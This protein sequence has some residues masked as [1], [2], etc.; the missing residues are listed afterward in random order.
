MCSE[1]KDFLQE[2]GVSL[3]F[4]NESTL[5]ENLTLGRVI[6][7][8]KGFYRVVTKDKISLCELSG[9]L[10]HEISEAAQYPTV[11]DFVMVEFP[12]EEGN[13]SIKNILSRKSM[14]IRK[15]VGVKG[16][17]QVVSAN[18]DIIFICMSL[19]ENYN[20]NRLE[21]YLSVA[22]DSGAK[23]VIVLTKSDLCE[24]INKVIY[25]VEKVSAYS[26][27]I[28]VSIYDEDI[29][30]KFK[31]YFNEETTASFIGSSGVGKSTLINKL[32]K[33]DVI[34]TGGLSR[35]DKGKHT[36]TVKQMHPCPFGGVLIDTPGMREIGL[37]NAD[38][39]KA[40]DD[41]DKLSM[42]C[43]FN[44]CTH[45]NEPGCAV[46]KAVEEGSVDMRRLENYYKLINESSYEGLNSKEIEK[47]KAN[48][49]FAEVGGMK[50]ARKYM[51]KNNK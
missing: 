9:K 44:D 50:N 17:G 42:E 28:T 49:M 34:L 21:R 6:A 31:G 20:L 45:T 35:D 14:F 37:E 3:R 12:L 7:E 38:V 16:Q 48:R 10:R 39:S 29:I 23:P 24:D 15:S 4:I 40:F 1:K 5:Y 19:N 47:K 46:L 26:D 13:G 41:I 51:K 30:S 36:T 25:E 27:V 22:F 8:Y 32:L 43:K 11:G 18:I 2:Y 33:E